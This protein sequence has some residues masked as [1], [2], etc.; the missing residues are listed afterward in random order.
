M[1]NY[2]ITAC[3]TF[4]VGQCQ[5]VHLASKNTTPTIS[6]GFLGDFLRL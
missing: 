5:E 3:S 2:L 1:Y 6:T 4:T